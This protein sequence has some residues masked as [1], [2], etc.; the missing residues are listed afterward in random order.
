MREDASVCV[1]DSGSYAS[2]IRTDAFAQGIHAIKPDQEYH[3]PGT[4]VYRREAWLSTHD[5]PHL[6][7]TAAA[8]FADL[9]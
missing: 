4:G 6:A 2:A 9:A 1:G 7:G 8:W 3:P 5:S